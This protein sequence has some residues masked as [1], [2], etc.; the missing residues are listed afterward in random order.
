MVAE[1]ATMAAVPPKINDRPIFKDA[2]AGSCT[3]KKLLML[4]K[5]VTLSPVWLSLYEQSWSI[6][7]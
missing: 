1:A 6:V 3:F 4:V 7:D 2:I 5:V